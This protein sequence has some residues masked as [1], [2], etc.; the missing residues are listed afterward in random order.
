MIASTALTPQTTQAQGG[1]PLLPFIG[2]GQANVSGNIL[3]DPNNVS[4][5]MAGAQQAGIGGQGLPGNLGTIQNQ[6][7][8]LN[9]SVPGSPGDSAGPSGGG[10]GYGFGGVQSPF[11]PFSPIGNPMLKDPRQ[12]QPRFAPV[13]GQGPMQPPAGVQLS[14]SPQAPLG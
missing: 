4:P 1:N 2:A 11:Q 6:A 5:A 12:K 3:T 7:P 10:G 14:Q 9:A 8:A 13:G